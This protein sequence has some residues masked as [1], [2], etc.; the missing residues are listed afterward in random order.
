MC[1]GPAKVGLST[2]AEFD[3][4]VISWLLPFFVVP[5]GASNLASI[6]TCVRFTYKV[7]CLLFV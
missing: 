5:I 7:L 1:I 6:G 2:L 3:F 4:D